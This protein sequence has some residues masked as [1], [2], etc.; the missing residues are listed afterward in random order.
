MELD[1]QIQS[2]LGS[3]RVLGFHD[4]WEGHDWRP[5]NLM[6]QDS[7]VVIEVWLSETTPE[8]TQSHRP[9]YEVEPPA[10][11]T[12]TTRRVRQVQRAKMTQLPES[13]QSLKSTQPGYPKTPNPQSAQQPQSYSQGIGQQSQSMTECEATHVFTSASMSHMTL[14][15]LT[16]LRSGSLLDDAT[17]EQRRLPERFSLLAPSKFIPLDEQYLPSIEHEDLNHETKRIV[18]LLR[19]AQAHPSPARLQI[20]LGRLLVHPDSVSKRMRSRPIPH[21]TWGGS[22]GMKSFFMA[23]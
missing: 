4:L 3:K 15:D 23:R 10:S 20:I 14:S 16:N 22:R 18:V 6:P 17:F 2:Y 19:L 13:T 8:P 21:S 9:D 12:Q 1:G 11:T 5:V 7:K